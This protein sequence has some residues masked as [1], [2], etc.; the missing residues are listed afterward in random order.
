MLI[1]NGCWVEDWGKMSHQ[2]SLGDEV[3]VTV[4][5]YILLGRTTKEVLLLVPRSWNQTGALL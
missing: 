2:G 1:H 5:P 3:H 4:S